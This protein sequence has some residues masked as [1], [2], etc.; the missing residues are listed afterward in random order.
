MVNEA[1]STGIGLPAPGSPTAAA[2]PR[3]F[4]ARVSPA[5]RAGSWVDVIPMS[6][7]RKGVVL[8]CCAEPAVA[9][10]LRTGARE[11]LQRTGDPVRTLEQMDGLPVSAMCAVID[12]AAVT[13]S[14]HDESA[15]AVVVPAGQ[16]RHLQAGRLIVCDL[17]PGATVLLSTAPLPGAEARLLVGAALHPDDLADRVLAA[18]DRSPGVVA[19]LYRHPPDPMTVTM[20]ASPPNLA[21]S[22]GLLRDWL[23]EAGVDPESCADVLLAVGEATANATEHSGLG[24]NHEVLLTVSATL[25]GNVL[26]LTVSDDGQWKP[27]AVTQGHRGHGMHLINALVDS[28]DVTAT[29]AGTTVAMR[30]ELP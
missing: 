6:D 10:R 29:P 7:G 8:G 26:K 9:T 4:A 22:R 20:P 3:G 19:I 30:K 1:V 5:V 27:A 2:L 18:A 21:I 15:N 16:R 17:R 28:V 13:I 25:D 11:A 12:S 24:T 23:T 14:V